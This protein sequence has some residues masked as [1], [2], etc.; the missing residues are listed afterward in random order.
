M[1][2][3]N[4]PKQ[5]LT[6]NQDEPLVYQRK[7]SHILPMY[8]RDWDRIKTMAG[9][10]KS[11]KHF[12]STLG[13]IALG[14]LSSALVAIASIFSERDSNVEEYHTLTTVFIIACSVSAICYI[15]AF[16]KK[17]ETN[18]RGEEL[19]AEMNDIES[20]FVSPLAEEKEYNI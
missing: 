13:S 17:K 4:M 12:F 10:I 14:V 7:Q 5:S 9:R 15:I 8:R 18:T 1:R 6:L 11:P 20:E 19:V 3:N 2:T 16:F